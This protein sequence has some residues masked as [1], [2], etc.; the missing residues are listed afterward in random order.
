MY[1]G[2]VLSRTLRLSL[3]LGGIAVNILA[4]VVG[5]SLDL[6]LL[7]FSER[8]AENEFT[9]GSVDNGGSVEMDPISHNVSFP[10]TFEFDNDVE[11]I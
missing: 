5:N 11:T 3:V 9:F 7:L 2:T 4:I 1:G 10:S 8:E 6:Y